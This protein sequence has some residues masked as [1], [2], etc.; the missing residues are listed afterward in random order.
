MAKITIDVELL[1]K[2]AR[3][4]I[5]KLN[6]EVQE[7]EQSVE[8]TNEASSELGGTLDSV[9]GGAVSGFKNMKTSLLSVAKGFRTLG[10]AIMATG[11]GALIIA[12]TAIGAAFTSSEEG[13]NKFAK[14]MTML[15]VITGNFMDILSDLGETLIDIF[16]SPI[17][18]L[19]NFRDSVK[20]FALDQFNM[21][22][23]SVGLLGSAFKKLFEGDFKGAFEDAADG[24]VTMNKAIN[25]VVIAQE[26]LFTGIR[27]TAKA[28]KDLV[29]ET[30]EEMLLASNI[31]DMRAKADKAERQ[32]IVD[33]AQANRDRADLLEKAVDKENFTSKQRIEFLKQ[34]G[35]LEEQ[36]TNQEIEAARLR[37][38]AKKA[39]NNLAKSTKADLD[40]EAALKAK[41]I[42]LETAKLTKAKEVTSQIIALNAEVKAQND[43]TIA[44]EK[45]KQDSIDAILLSYK[46][47]RE[48]EEATSY[49]AKLELEEKRK[50]EELD[51]LQATEEQKQAI[52]DFYSDKRKQQDTEEGED[53]K[54]ML[55][56][57]LD[58]V[59]MIAGEES[60]IATAIFLF[61]QSQRIQDQIEEAKATLSKITMKASEATVATAAGA[62]ETSK[63]GFP[64]NIPLLIA[65]GVQAAGIIMSVNSAVQAAKSAVGSSVPS[66][67][68]MA[69]GGSASVSTVP[70]TPPAFNIVGSSPENQLAQAIGENEK[71]PVRSFV[72]GSDISTQ[73]ALD[74]NIVENATL[75]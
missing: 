10:G 15:S 9:T 49:L 8:Q 35:E 25:P 27:K 11:L 7:V 18:A 6:E 70:P 72:V 4:E 36:I 5:E 30:K 69:G 17:D 22:M 65:F 33:R 57:G 55:D 56:D 71:K 42:D 50:L 24:V 63:A 37:F 43:A 32:L 29:K 60:K 19:K 39:E 46:Q 44:E 2:D 21:L 28:V 66:G 23:E 45:A 51:R 40:E 48:D 74:R 14:A 16:T 64:Q 73:Q 26:A 61:K 58:Q 52:R 20:K 68:A 12:I 13:Q 53:K 67:G 1:S 3:K 31:A 54:K 41:L 47:K 62:A 75:G 38:E 59:A 34:A